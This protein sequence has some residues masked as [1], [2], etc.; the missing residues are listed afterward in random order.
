MAAYD[1]YDYPKYW[2]HRVY[3]HESEIVAIK[4]FFKKIGKNK[5]IIDIG[6]GY[7]RLAKTYAKFADTITLVEPSRS[8]LDKAQKILGKHQNLNLV[9]S[10]IQN[11]DQKIKAK[12]YDVV[13]LVRV[14]H[15]IDD[16]ELAIKKA[17]K[18]LE[19]GGYFILEFANKIH[20]KAIL[21]NILSGNFTF[22][23]DIFPLDKRSNKNIKN[24]SILFLNHHPDVIEKCLKDNGFKV[25]EKRSVSNIRST[26]VK[27]MVP[28]DVLLFVEAL[29]QKLLA[30]INFGPSIFIL[31]RKRR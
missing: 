20:G 10:T 27:S 21:K 26:R 16:P 18:H 24:K 29:F 12:K 17:N 3:E 23:I 11:M 14:M 6:A 13:M 30:K 2:D 19:K 31:A 5:N 28:L 8:L 1:G 9:N 22:P 25:I 7:G 4:S 15:H